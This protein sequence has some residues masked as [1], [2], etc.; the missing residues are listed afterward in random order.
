MAY[1]DFEIIFGRPMAGCHVEDHG[2][3]WLVDAIDMDSRD[4]PVSKE[5]CGTFFND[6]DGRPMTGFYVG[7]RFPKTLVDASEDGGVTPMS[8]LGLSPTEGQRAEVERA[9]A[10]LPKEVLDSPDLL[11]LGTYFLRIE[12]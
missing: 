4:N 10:L 12:C 8:S 2:L 1:T 3:E 5:W 9:L 6:F 7:H 11:P